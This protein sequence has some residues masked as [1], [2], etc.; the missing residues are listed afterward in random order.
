MNGDERYSQRQLN[1]DFLF[2]PLRRFRQG[3]HKLQ[4]LSEVS[5]RFDVSG[6]P[7]RALPSI[8]PAT[9][10]PL[11]I[12]CFLIVIGQDFGLIFG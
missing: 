10:G 2:G 8:E 4:C 3:A 1:V 6:M 9:N 7:K 5:N 12:A 11:V